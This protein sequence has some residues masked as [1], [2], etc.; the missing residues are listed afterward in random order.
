MMAEGDLHML[1]LRLDSGRL[2]ALG[3]RLRLP[4]HHLDPGYLVHCL[5]GGLFGDDAPSPFALGGTH[6]RTLEVLAYARRDGRALADHAQ[7]FARPEDYAACDWASL[8]TKPMPSRWKP[9]ARVRFRLRACP[10]VRLASAG[11]RHRKGAEVDAFLARCWAVG[12]GK[13]VDRATTYVDWLGAQLDRRGGATLRRARVE[14]FQRQ[15]FLRRDHGTQ[16][17]SH[18]VERPDV[19]F[20]GEVELTDGAAFSALLG[21][22]IGRHRSFGFGML[23]LR[24]ARGA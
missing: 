8:A 15:R 18:A 6:G 10:V 4:S 1:Q 23:L 3:R 11:A 14:A 5:L 7:H 22:G 17:K 21:R 19:I 13:P 16:R 12:E 9:G 20:D 2:A 24:P